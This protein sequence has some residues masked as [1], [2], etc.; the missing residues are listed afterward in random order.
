MTTS[1]SNPTN[2]EAYDLAAIK[3]ELRVIEAL[4]PKLALYEAREFRELPNQLQQQ[5]RTLKSI[6]QPTASGLERVGSLLWQL[7]SVTTLLERLAHGQ[8]IADQLDAL[9]RPLPDTL[10]QMGPTADVIS[11]QQGA[12]SKEQGAESPKAL[13]AI[14][15][16]GGTLVLDAE[17][18]TDGKQPA[19]SAGGRTAEARPTTPAAAPTLTLESEQGAA[20]GQPTT[21]GGTLVLPDEVA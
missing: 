7:A 8:S 18:T 20:D 16:R 15:P 3:A 21:G 6:N 1:I 4:R 9:G 19:S 10:L 12:R 17:P 2:P 5:V 14:L 11:N 13:G